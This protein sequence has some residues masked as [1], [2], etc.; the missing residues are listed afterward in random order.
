MSERGEWRHRQRGAQ[1]LSFSGL[2]WGTITP[3]DFD[4]FIDF[5][6]RAFVLGELKYRD[7]PMPRGQELALERAVDTWAHAGVPTIGFIARHH[8]DIGEVAVA[9]AEVVKIR[10]AG[11]WRMQMELCTVASLIDRFHEYATRQNAA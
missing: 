3:T 5:G 1:L 6:G 4:L 2:R 7:A 9:D 10:W 11:V 8:I